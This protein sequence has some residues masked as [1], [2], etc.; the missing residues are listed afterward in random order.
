MRTTETVLLEATVATI[1]LLRTVKGLRHVVDQGERA[2]ASA[3]TQGIEGLGRTGRDQQNRLRVSY[4]ECGEAGAVLK[5]LA[6]LGDLDRGRAA[7]AM[8]RWDHARALL[9]K[10]LQ[11]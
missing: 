2:A 9:Y 1:R 10:R 3:Y 11:R 4:A 5:L 6:T 7:A 8:D